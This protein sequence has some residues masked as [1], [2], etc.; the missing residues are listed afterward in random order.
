MKTSTHVPIISD[1]YFFIL[2]VTPF[3]YDVALGTCSP[4]PKHYLSP[5][6]TV[7]F[8]SDRAA[9]KSGSA[10]RKPGTGF[11]DAISGALGRLAAQSSGLKKCYRAFFSIFI[12]QVSV[13]KPAPAASLPETADALH[14]TRPKWTF[15]LF[16]LFL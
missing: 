3:L 4:Y 11:S 5:D 13:H 15:L 9:H 6:I 12:L 2:F 7:S 8:S 10:R 16:L 14:Y 1:K